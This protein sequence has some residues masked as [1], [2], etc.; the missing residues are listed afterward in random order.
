MKFRKFLK[1]LFSIMTASAIALSVMTCAGP[2]SV[3]VEADEQEELEKQLKDFAKK[4]EE[5]E[6]KIKE[7]KKDI[8]KEKENQEAISEQ[9]ETTEEYIRVLVELIHEIQDEIDA[10]EDEIGALEGDIEIQKAKIQNKREEIDENIKIYER[11]LRAMYLSG[12]D[13]VASIVLGATDFFD[14]LMKIELIKRVSGYNND[15]IQTLLD[16]KAEY[17]AAQLDLE[18]QV[19]SL[20]ELVEINEE[21]KAEQEAHKADWDEKLA[22]LQELYSESSAAISE[23]KEL[24][25]GYE[26]DAE[27]YEKQEKELDEKIKELI[28][29]KAR[30]NY[31]GDLEEG[32]FLWPLPGYYTITSGY[33]SRWGTTHRGIDISGSN[34]MGADITAANSGEVI[35]VYNGCSHNYGKK[36]SKFCH[37]GGGFGNY[38]IIDHGG[39]YQ[40]VYGHATKITVKEGQMVKTGDVI[41]TVGSTGDSTGAHLHFEVRIDGERVDPQGSKVNLIKY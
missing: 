7:T 37:C 9:I 20:E 28:R 29:Q 17:E 26:E 32:T 19:A 23:L 13:S 33:G 6:A 8:S 39:G 27:F 10:L 4:R 31:M 24:Q 22:E 14:L 41:G 18:N 34:V 30:A 35:F 21:K 40:T 38:C 15:V 16:I 2:L 1:P 3:T 25:N 11:Q 12:N 5:T 36:S